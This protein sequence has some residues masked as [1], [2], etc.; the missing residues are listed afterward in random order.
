MSVL[1]VGPDISQTYDLATLHTAYV[2][3]KQTSGTK[4]L[5]E[6]KAGVQL[7]FSIDERFC[8]K[9]TGLTREETSVFIALLEHTLKGEEDE[10]IFLLN[11]G[12][13]E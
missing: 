2:R 9:E 8:N 1:T 10:F 11:Y 5:L 12:E 6:T 3:D 4:P 13:S 7:W